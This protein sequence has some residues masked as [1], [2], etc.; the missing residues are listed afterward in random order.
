M[1]SIIQ[2]KRFVRVAITSD[3]KDGTMKEIKVDEQEVF[4]AKVGD[5]IYAADNICPHMGGQIGAR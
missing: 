4:L 2:T 3:L 5:K 1:A